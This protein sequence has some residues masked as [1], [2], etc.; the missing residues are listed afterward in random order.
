MS[1]RTHAHTLTYNRIDNGVVRLSINRT[2][3]S[4][5]MRCP[6][7]ATNPRNEF[8]S[9]RSS[10][11]PI[12]VAPS[13]SGGG[14]GYPAESQVGLPTSMRANII[15]TRLESF[16]HTTR[17]S[18]RE[19]WPAGKWALILLLVFMFVSRLVRGWCGSLGTTQRSETR[20]KWEEGVGR[21]R[22]KWQEP[23]S[24]INRRSWFMFCEE[25]LPSTTRI[26]R[27]VPSSD[28]HL[29]FKVRRHEHV[30][31]SNPQTQ[32]NI[33]ELRRTLNGPTC[34][35]VCQDRAE[36]H[37]HQSVRTEDWRLSAPKIEKPPARRYKF[38]RIL[39]FLESFANG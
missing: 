30:K 27:Y 23:R 5:Q 24:E 1:Q 8:L 4:S 9:D 29:E 19:Q 12:I 6:E 15:I 20:K 17:R 36:A 28:D 2:L 32:N 18:P 37:N 3:V 16:P 34:R 31:G 39:F 13:S 25:H 7:K 21:T 33:L 35:N 38:D 11:E 26:Q 10:Q 22:G 14:K